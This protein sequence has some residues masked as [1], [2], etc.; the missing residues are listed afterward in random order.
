MN[1]RYGDEFL[2]CCA[3][4]IGLS[5]STGYPAALVAAVGMPVPCLMPE[6]RKSAF[7][8][9]LGYYAAGL[10]PMIPG[11]QRYIGH[12]APL[13]IAMLIWVCTTIFLSVPWTLAWTSG[14]RLH[15]LWR[16]PLANLAIIVPPLGLIGFISPLSGAGCLFPGTGWLGLAITSL[17]PAIVLALGQSTSGRSR[18]YLCLGMAAVVALGFG[19]QASVP[20]EANTPANWEAANTNFGDLSRPFQDFAAAQSIREHVAKSS[21]KVLIFPEFVIPRWSDATREFW[22]PTLDECRTHGKIVAVGAGLPRTLAGMNR[23]NVDLDLVKSYDFAAAIQALQMNKPLLASNPDSPAMINT[24]PEPFD[25]TLL[26]LG[27]E[28]STFYQRVPVPIGMW[29]PFRDDGV[30]L[31]LDA[32]GVIEMDGQRVAVLICYE[33]ILTYPILASMLQHPTVLVGISNVFWFADTP[34]PRYQA[35]ALRAW[36]RLFHIPFLSA[37][38]S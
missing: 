11:S 18:L 20:I 27:A 9:I 2:F 28:S 22:R 36:A 14:C 16:L 15:Y 25:N 33:Q 10:W 24:A 38:N 30:P 23:G 17:L 13:P 31:R 21:A 35:S 3:V 26:I 12:A 1:T 19:A 34:I 29:R 6:S 37:V 5:V 32:P 8:N 7:I 4:A